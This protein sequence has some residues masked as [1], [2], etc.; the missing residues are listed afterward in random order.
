MW[1]CTT[2]PVG[3]GL[4][5]AKIRRVLIKLKA[6]ELSQESETLKN[7]IVHQLIVLI[8][9]STVLYEP[10]VRTAPAVDQGNAVTEEKKKGK[11]AVEGA[12]EEYILSAPLDRDTNTR[13]FI[14]RAIHA[15]MC[16][17]RGHSC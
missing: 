17:I 8:P 15:S 6:K 16:Q 2:L 12:G 1:K 9:S 13:V 10:V 11:E 3:G 5:V 7:S 4:P 14:V